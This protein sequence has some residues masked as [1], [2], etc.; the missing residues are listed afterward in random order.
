MTPK[1]KL[2]IVL[3][4]IFIAQIVSTIGLDVLHWGIWSI[5]I[6]LAMIISALI[7]QAK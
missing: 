2:A 4:V 1:E 6:Q 5:V 7:W 3:A